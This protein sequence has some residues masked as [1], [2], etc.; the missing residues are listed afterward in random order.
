[1]KTSQRSPN[2][3]RG[4]YGA[5]KAKSER[6]SKR[7]VGFLGCGS[8]SSGCAGIRG[9][10]DGLPGGCQSVNDKDGLLAAGVKIGTRGKRLNRYRTKDE[11]YE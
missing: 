8:A 10:W 1:M 3:Q 4:S 6:I 2:T 9:C 7:S 5:L 11:C